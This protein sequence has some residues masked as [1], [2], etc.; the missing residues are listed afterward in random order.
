MVKDLKAYNEF[1]AKKLS[2]IPNIS[3]IKSSFVMSYVKQ[4]TVLP[5]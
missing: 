2:V 5:F 1:I 3:K 4:S